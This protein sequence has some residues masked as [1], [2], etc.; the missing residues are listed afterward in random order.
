MDSEAMLVPSADTLNGILAL[1]SNDKYKNGI[2]S[3]ECRSAQ[4]IGFYAV[5]RINLKD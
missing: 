4:S 5:V 1:A 3:V 2:K